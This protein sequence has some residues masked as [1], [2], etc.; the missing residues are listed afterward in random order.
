MPVYNML[1]VW[2]PNSI[3]DGIDKLICNFIWNKGESR[4]LNLVNWKTVM[5]AKS[6]GGLRVCQAKLTNI[7]MIGKLV[8]DFVGNSSRSMVI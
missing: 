5:Y 4:G 1:S 2:M 3:C 6:Y 7:A 8:V